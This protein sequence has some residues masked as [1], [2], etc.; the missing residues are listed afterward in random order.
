MIET[1]QI[2]EEFQLRNVLATSPTGAIF[3]AGD[4]STGDDLVIKVVSCAVPGAEDDVR[5][6]FL[7]MAVAARSARI[8][9]MPVLLDHGLTPEGD[10]F[11]VMEHIEGQ[12]LDSVEDFS[13]FASINILLDVLTCIEGLAEAGTAHLNITPSNIHLI[14][15]PTNDRAVVLGFG[16][17]ATLLHAGVGVPIPARDPHLAPE[18]V[19]GELLPSEDGWRS[20]LFSLGVIACGILGAEIEANGYE[21]PVVTLPE[22]VRSTLPEVDPLEEILAQVMAPDPMLRGSSPS[23]ARDPL[24]R[25][26]PDP[27]R[28]AVAAAPAVNASTGQ[29][30]DPA[31]T[32]PALFP[33]VQEPVEESA[34]SLQTKIGD[35]GGEETVSVEVDEGWPEVLFDDPELPSSLSDPGP[36]PEDTDVRNPVPEDV[37]VPRDELEGAEGVEPAATALAVKSAGGRRVTRLEL[38]VVA[39][40]VI[41]LGAILALTWPAGRDQEALEIGQVIPADQPRSDDSLVPPPPDDNLFDDLLSIQALV[42]AGDLEAARVAIDELDGRNDLL[43]NSDESALYNSL[44]ASVARATDRDAAID[45]LQTGLEHGSIRMIRR[46]AAGL[47]GMPR[48]EIAEYLGLAGDIDRARRVLLLHSEMWDAEKE[49][50]H[51][52][53]IRYA[54]ELEREFPGY[55]GAP[56]AR[57]RA[58]VA[59]ETRAEGAAERGAFDDSLAILESLDRVWP[60]RPGLSERI[61]RCSE[62]VDASRR[63]ES[64]IESAW[65]LGR[66]G[67]PEGGLARL[68]TLGSDAGTTAEAEEARSALL[69]QLKA[70]DEQ[71]PTI[72]FATA[73]DLGFKKN[74]TIIVPLRIRDDYSVE[75]VVVF[76]RNKGDDGFLRIVIDPGDDGLYH[77]S[78]TPELHGNKDVFFY[79]VAEDRSGHVGRMGDAGM[80]LT[81]ERKKWFKK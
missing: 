18:L 67:D 30:F 78:V 10:G 11:L 14:H 68:D 7:A 20:D 55:G 61:R 8:G 71:I 65:A 73:M 40:V 56:D 80:P 16:T 63:E 47:N 42:D 46:G 41:V 1:R 48:D 5:R 76:A 36:D 75:R 15:P 50:D 3:L 35:V 32:D 2:L 54:G 60:N 24:I 22:T 49:G 38:A 45:D 29:G 70:M 37:W 39:V 52:G 77:F 64:V 62:Q 4:P 74:A 28:F 25:A 66:A 33:E 6:L 23:D 43:L 27:P 31:K 57:E 59:V 79:V 44:V 26:L 58:A 81:I 21:K 53:A 34:A 13:P 51:L 19:A 72:E 12:S 17:S 69:N 9:A